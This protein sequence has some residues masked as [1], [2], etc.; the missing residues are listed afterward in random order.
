MAATTPEKTRAPLEKTCDR[1]TLCAALQPTGPAP[2]ACAWCNVSMETSILIGGGYYKKKMAV[3]AKVV[4]TALGDVHFF[5]ITKKSEW[6]VKCAGGAAGQTGALRNSTVIDDL[7][8]KFDIAA[9]AA[10]GSPGVELAVAGSDDPMAALD[11]IVA[12]TPDGKRRKMSYNRKRKQDE[13]YTVDMPARWKDVANTIPIRLITTSTNSLW[14]HADHIHWLVVYVA[15]ELSSGGV[16]VAVAA[17]DEC[18]QLLPNT[19]VPDLHIRWDFA[20]GD[21]WEAIFVAGRKA[22]V[23]VVSSISKLTTAK[24][25]A[26]GGHERFGTSLDDATLQQRKDAVWRLLEIHCAGLLVHHGAAEIRS[27][28]SAEVVS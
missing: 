12:G 16:R 13:I 20:S 8:K 11:S 3:D 7:R 15:D 1:D 5:K 22:G 10:A 24:W 19:S 23:R 26:I 28:G 2:S 4:N 27:G 18:D 17:D 21:S 25:N 9:F 14:I 6:L